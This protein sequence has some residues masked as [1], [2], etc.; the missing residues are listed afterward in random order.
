M[1]KLKLILFLILATCIAYFSSLAN[2]FIWDD[3]QFITSNV[4]VQQFDV[5]KIFTT[6]TI[7]GAGDVSNYYRPLTSL[8]FAIDAKIW[9]QN[10]F[11]FHLTNISLHISSG[12]LLFLLLDAIGIGQ[13]GSFFISLIFLIFPS[14][15]EAVTFINSR[16]D[17]LYTAFLFLSLFLFFKAFRQNKLSLFFWS[18][19]CYM[20]S[21]FSKETAISAFPLFFAITIFDR[22]TQRGKIFKMTKAFKRTIVFTCLSFAGVAVYMLLRLT[23]LN[24]SNTLNYYS[25]QTVYS[26]HLDIRLL[27]FARILWTYMGILLWPQSLHME[28]SIRLV[29]SIFSWEVWGILLL[30]V[31]IVAFGIW[32]IRK[33]KSAFML[34]G[35]FWA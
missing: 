20:M 4:Y 16:G 3:E 21:I 35:F 6:N 28:R 9:R 19:I 7:A 23:V 17:S 25:E 24:F 26:S 27:T 18:F 12:V 8:S 2:P 32:E 11:G 1:S 15:V 33:K 31:A 10:S 14:Q 5:G 34:F 29:T 22:F 13:L 30:F